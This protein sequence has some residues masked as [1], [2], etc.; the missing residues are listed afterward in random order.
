MKLH[1]RFFILALF[2]GAILA[3]PMVH[4]AESGKKISSELAEKSV[5]SPDNHMRVIIKLKNTPHQRAF[6][7][8]SIKAGMSS[9]RTGA[10]LKNQNI[11]GK[12][13]QNSNFL[14]AEVPLGKIKS[15]AS[16]ENV[17]YIEEDKIMHAF[18]S[19]S[20]PL[21]GANTVWGKQILGENITGAGTSVCIIDT[22]V[23]YTHP[24]L[25]NCTQS[26]F[27]GGN[28]S[29]V[30]GGYDFVNSDEDPRDDNGHGTHVAGIVAANGTLKGVAPDAKIVAIKALDSYGGGYE[31]DIISGIDWCIL[32]STKF[33]ISVI[34]MSLGSNITYTSYCDNN[35]QPFRDAINA[36]VAQNI[37]VVVATGNDR[38]TTA[39]AAPACIQNA[40]RVTATDKND[41]YAYFADRAASFPDIL[42]A[43]GVNINSTMLSTNKLPECASSQLYCV[44]SGTSM[45]APHVSG[46]IALLSQAY[47]NTYNSGQTPAYFKNLLNSTGKQI[48]DAGT[49]MGFSRINVSAAYSAIT[50]NPIIISQ[51]ANGTFINQSSSIIN[52]SQNIPG[53]L[54]FSIDDGSNVSACFRCTSFLNSTGDLAD[55]VHNI[56]VYGNNSAIGLNYTILYFTI[57]TIKPAIN[58]VAVF[59]PVSYPGQNITISYSVVDISPVN[60]TVNIEHS[61]VSEQFNLSGA[62]SNYTMVFSNT[63]DA[64]EY[65]ITIF[66]TDAMNHTSGAS[67]KF[68]ILQKADVSFNFTA[69]IPLTLRIKYNGTE[70]ENISAN[71]TEKRNA[72][73]GSENYSLEAQGGNKAFAITLGG[74]EFLQ[75]RTLGISLSNLSASS[76]DSSK[77]KFTNNSFSFS[78]GFNY[79]SATV[80][81]N[82]TSYAGKFLNLS[83]M[84]NFKCEGTC[85][86][87]EWAAIPTSRNE[88]TNQSCSNVTSFSSFVLGETL[89]FCGDGNIDAG[90]TCNSCPADAGACPAPAPATSSGGGGGGGSWILVK[91]EK[92]TNA[93]NVPN[94]SNNIVPGSV[95]ENISSAQNITEIKTTAKN[96]S[97]KI[98]MTEKT[99]RN[100]G[101]TGFFAM[102][103]IEWIVS[104]VVKFMVYLLSL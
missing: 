67:A 19:E 46:A 79:S 11:S 45:S 4:A 50:S 47:R 74:V 76:P 21:I 44:L 39:I 20:V 96:E 68:R 27:L 59:P 9:S 85:S 2:L 8:S 32:N 61:N 25:G 38:N 55:G 7:G 90:E 3:Y 75:N 17:E 98:R 95:V 71:A 104:A 87:G 89:P 36:A 23:D 53:E 16:D 31:S 40:T 102:H 91:P 82:Y 51:P 88:L 13:L 65:N 6:L 12:Q 63:S 70:I 52:A 24:D 93:S 10:L 42:A 101:T 80:C 37:S 26:Q 73:F 54:W 78:P 86:S 18:L 29:K 97:S 56:T 81:F 14:V 57:D 48:S 92:I 60:T 1:V 28:C 49:G 84:T 94:M 33:N 64:G 41:S 99:E 35:E 15:I 58:N 83:R 100:S 69:N 34:S 30:I 5:S 43:P 77:Y 62:D 103:Y 22:G 66:A 72:S